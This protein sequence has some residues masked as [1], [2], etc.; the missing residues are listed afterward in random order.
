MNKTQ[1]LAAGIVLLLTAGLYLATSPQIF[2]TKEHAPAPRAPSA[3]AHQGELTIDTILLHARENLTQLQQNRLNSLNNSLKQ[4]GTE[5]KVHLNHHL[6]RYWKDSVRMFEPY[7]WYTAEAARLEN[8]EK[9]LTFA[10]H[11]FLD[12]LKRESNPEL[13]HW[14]AHQATDL[15]ERSLKINPANDSSA[16]GLGAVS[17][18]GG[19]SENPMEGIQRIRSVVD[20]D[21]NH[22]YALMTL[23]HASALSGQ[24]DKAIERFN[25]V[26]G[27]QPQNLEAVLSLADAY[28]RQGDRKNAIAWYR[29]SLTIQD[30]PGLKEEVENRIKTLSQ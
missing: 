5:E 21:P 22:V 29:K 9:S 18:F 10:A 28:E 19:M 27:L 15:F 6:A 30:I 14:K 24:W 8:S 1:W 4:A 17:L 2:G 20:K 13:K 12:D 16:V 11:L 25:R 23:G 3:A 26:A 7:A